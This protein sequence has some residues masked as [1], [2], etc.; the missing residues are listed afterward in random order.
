MSEFNTNKNK[1]AIL[2]I[3][4]FIFPVFNF[5]FAQTI[6]QPETLEEAGEIGERALNVGEEQMPGT[7]E[8]IWKEE[9]L[10]IWQKMYN[11]AKR[12]FWDYR[13]GPWLKNI[14]QG[15]VRVFNQEAEKR[16]PIIQEEFAKEK[17]ELKQEAPQ[18][19]KTLWE[20][21]KELIR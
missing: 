13:L 7:L 19:G 12:N 6:T 16:E 20:K 10:P 2:L 1:L 17:K 9:A 4:F 3:L 18:V 5:A 21:L 8:K 11:W 14:W 15:T